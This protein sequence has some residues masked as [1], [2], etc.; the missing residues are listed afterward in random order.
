LG[1]II[2]ADRDPSFGAKQRYGASGL[3]P[4]AIRDIDRCDVHRNGAEEGHQAAIRNS[5]AAV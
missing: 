4:R 3:N 5:M 2:R 1:N